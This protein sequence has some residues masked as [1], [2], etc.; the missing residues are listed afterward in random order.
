MKLVFGLGTRERERERVEWNL[1]RIESAR[2]SETEP[3]SPT[4]WTAFY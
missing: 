2:R 3:S 4:G 1:G